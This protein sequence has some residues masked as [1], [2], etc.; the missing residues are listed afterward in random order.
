MTSGDTGGH[1]VEDLALLGGEE[2]VLYRFP[3]GNVYRAIARDSLMDPVKAA[4][5]Q[6]AMRAFQREG[7]TDEEILEIAQTQAAALP[8]IVRLLCPTVPEGL[9]NEV[10][11]GFAMGL[12][13]DFLDGVNGQ[14]MPPAIQD[15]L[16]RIAERATST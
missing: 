16:T 4:Q 6:I 5:L 14:V 11:P 12:L 15:R 13:A 2:G 10:S 9:E 7:E 8:T 3:D 1:I